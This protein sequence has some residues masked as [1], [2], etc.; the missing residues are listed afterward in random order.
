MHTYWYHSNHQC[1]HT[2]TMI[3]INAYILGPWFYFHFKLNF[4]VELNF[5]LL[6]TVHLKGTYCIFI[7]SCALCFTQNSIHHAVAYSFWFFF[8]VSACFML[9]P[10]VI[11]RGQMKKKLFPWLAVWSP[12]VRV[13]KK[14]KGHCAGWNVLTPLTMF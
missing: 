13:L 7:S 6:F 9:K 8:F 3:T 11:K 1:I 4:S 5:Q 10:C 2:C 14:F 12:F